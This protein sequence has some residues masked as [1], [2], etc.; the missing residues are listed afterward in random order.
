M[1]IAHLVPR[2]LQL[3][4]IRDQIASILETELQSQQAIAVTQGEDPLKWDARVFTQRR[5]PWDLF[6]DAPDNETLDARAVVVVNVNNAQADAASGSGTQVQHLNGDYS[7]L[8][9]GYGK[10]EETAEGHDPQDVVASRVAQ[11]A[12]GVVYNVLRNGMYSL[13]GMKGI[14][15]N[16]QVM[17]ITF[18]PQ[19]VEHQEP[20]F[21]VECIEVALKVTFIERVEPNAGVQFERVKIDH[22]K[23]TP[24]GQILLSQEEIIPTGS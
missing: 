7:V 18:N 16:Y 10:A 8:C 9:Y 23:D 15:Q 19:N 1:P 21:H 12:V 14:V 2:T 13:L 17:G 20:A 24:T 4:E 11:E 6:V 5:N 3:F 22:R